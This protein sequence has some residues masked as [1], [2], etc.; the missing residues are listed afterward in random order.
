[1]LVWKDVAP[2]AIFGLLGRYEF[3]KDARDVNRENLVSYIE[4]QNRRGE[5]T[6]WD[7]VL[8][9]GNPK[10]EPYAW[11][12]N[13]VTHRFLRSPITQ[14]SIGILAS[15]NDKRLWREQ[16]GRDPNDPTRGALF[17]T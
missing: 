10:Q 14:K 6:A 11:T 16:T 17:F 7:I 5:L 12:P 4:E 15:P 1:L 2:D 8:P 3:S 13:I 9:R